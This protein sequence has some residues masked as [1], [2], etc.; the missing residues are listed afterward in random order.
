MR[1][2]VQFFRL[3]HAFL[4]KLVQFLAE[5]LVQVMAGVVAARGI[6]SEL[7]ANTD[8][9]AVIQP[10]TSAHGAFIDFYVLFGT[11]EMLLHLLPVTARAQAPPLVLDGG[12]LH[13]G[14]YFHQFFA[15]VFTGLVEFPE[16]ELI[17]PDAAAAVPADVQFHPGDGDINQLRIACRTMHSCLLSGN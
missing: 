2:A 17:E 5:F 7:V 1:E 15:G 4:E 6:G 8:Q 12:D 3:L 14:F 13:A 9:F 11:V 10:D 16:F